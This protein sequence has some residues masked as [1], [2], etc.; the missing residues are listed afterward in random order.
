MRAILA[1]L[2]LA[3][4][5]WRAGVDWQATIGQGY[6]F[7]LGTIG[8]LIAE[9]WPERLR[10]PGRRALQAQRRA[11]RLEPGRARS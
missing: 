3:A 7:R 5:F 2:L 1:V 9:H 4:A 8:S 11:L 10:P 6:A